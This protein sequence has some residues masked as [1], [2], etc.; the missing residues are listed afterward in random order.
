MHR[1]F[2][3]F[4]GGKKTPKVY[5]VAVHP[6]QPHL[7]M[8]GTN[9]GSVL[10]GVDAP[11]PLAAAALPLQVRVIALYTVRIANVYQ[12]QFYAHGHKPLP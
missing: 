9:V 8:V 7:V 5:S 12:Q 11:P 6:A 10:L 1:H 2:L 4:S 3:R